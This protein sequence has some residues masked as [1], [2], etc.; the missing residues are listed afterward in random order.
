MAD[1]LHDHEMELNVA[2]LAA[3]DAALDES[4]VQDIPLNQKP[5]T[6]PAADHGK[7]AAPAAD[8]VGEES[9]EAGDEEI[10]GIPEAAPG[11]T[12]A[13]PATEK[14]P[15]SGAA[16]AESAKPA[17]APLSST[18]KD[19]NQIPTPKNLSPKG[20]RNWAELR[21]LASHWKK[22]AEDLGVQLDTL[23]GRYNQ[24]Q[25][26]AGGDPKM[27]ERIKALEQELEGYQTI[28]QTESSPAFRAKFDD[29]IKAN[30]TEIYTILGRQGL[31]KEQIEALQKVGGLAFAPDNFTNFVDV[32]RNFK[33]Q[34]PRIVSQARLDAKKLEDLVSKNMDLLNER[35]HTLDSI[36]G[37]RE[38]FHKA[39]QE[40]RAQSYQAYDTA[41]WQHYEAITK[42]IP[43]ARFQEIPANATPEQKAE[44]EQSNQLFNFLRPKFESA[45]F[46]ATPQARAEV[47]AT[48]CLAFVLNLELEAA[49]K[50]LE[51]ERG[52]TKAE[53]DR[54]DA[55]QKKLDSIQKAGQ[56]A[57]KGF[58]APAT[59]NK[60]TT[61]DRLRLSNE[62]AIDAGLAEAGL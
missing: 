24:V 61:G 12:P 17:A 25:K 60:P 62:D 28:Y 10:P 41:F 40:R 56:T 8:A 35:Q 27:A 7:A 13:T 1:E 53:K 3:L 47:A 15:A 55:L 29:A 52:K 21:Q 18:T 9:G 2:D 42:D 6:A 11:G 57:G 4:G 22:Q 59:P 43:Y 31:N 51:S 38:K 45:K 48:V 50:N 32:L 26:T 19:P 34:D 5:G 39:E 14:T 46:P 54:A 16:P 30:D 58:A 37:N 23:K 33:S 49:Q 44:I 36:P 20:N